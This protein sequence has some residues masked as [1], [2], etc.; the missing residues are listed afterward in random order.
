MPPV[1][2]E[3]VVKCFLSTHCVHSVLVEDLLK[4]SCPMLLVTWVLCSPCSF[5]PHFWSSS[6]VGRLATFHPIPF[7]VLSK[8]DPHPPMPYIIGYEAAPS[9]HPPT[10]ELKGAAGWRDASQ[11][12][13]ALVGYFFGHS[14]SGDVHFSPIM[15]PIA[16]QLLK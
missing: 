15:H 13:C 8:R 12:Y 10:P 3:P 11:S 2:S 16:L 4:Q 7:F 9:P 14:S 6:G 5:G 1:C